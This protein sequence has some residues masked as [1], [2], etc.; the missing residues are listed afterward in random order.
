MLHFKNTAFSSKN[1]GHLFSSKVFNSVSFAICIFLS[2]L[3]FLI[4]FYNIITSLPQCVKSANRN[5]D[6]FQIL[7]YYC[8]YLCNLSLFK[9]INTIDSHVLKL[10]SVDLSTIT[11]VVFLM[12]FLRLSWIFYQLAKKNFQVIYSVDFPF[13]SNFKTTFVQLGL[14]GTIFGFM[15]AFNNENASLKEYNPS[16]IF[17]ALGTALYSTF[18][19]IFI[20]YIIAPIFVLPVFGLLKKHIE[21]NILGIQ[22]DSKNSF[23]LFIS[24][25]NDTHKAFDLL[26][27][28]IN[29][30]SSSL[31]NIQNDLT[32]LPKIEKIERSLKSLEAYILEM[33]ANFNSL[34]EFIIISIKTLQE[35]INQLDKSKSNEI[36]NL[37]KRIAVFEDYYKKQMD[38]SARKS[39][40]RQIQD[41]LN[42]F[43]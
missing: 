27:Q 2:I 30:T 40:L 5:G 35:N 17:A 43:E 26:K 34:R 31:K 4:W 24:K 14:L 36:S 12:I 9:T 29:S 22:Q 42:S 6:F 18:I 32:F 15:V 1:I 13:W 20:G 23:S 7:A 8:Q 39:K 38:T 19:P 41:M 28:D 25:L 16:V 3:S 21:Q 37:E 10:L 33:P 11:T